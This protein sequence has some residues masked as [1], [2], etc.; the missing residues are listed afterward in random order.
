MFFV[1]RLRNVQPPIYNALRLK[2]RP[3]PETSVENVTPMIDIIL[4]NDQHATIFVANDSANNLANVSVHD[5][6]TDESTDTPTNDVAN[7]N[8]QMISPS[9]M[10]V[11]ANNSA[12]ALDHGETTPES[13]DI[14]PNDVVN[15][16][17][18]IVS[19]SVMNVSANNSAN[20]PIY[21]ESTNEPIDTPPNDV[22]N[23]IDHI[24]SPSVVNFSTVTGEFRDFG[25]PNDDEHH[26]NLN[27]DENLMVIQNAQ[28]TTESDPL[29][30]ASN[31]IKTET[32][33]IHT[34]NADQID[35]LLNQSQDSFD[36]D[37]YDDDLVFFVPK[38]G[39]PQPPIE[40]IS[41]IKRE[42]DE[43]SGDI[44]YNESV[45]NLL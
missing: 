21:D 42:G 13:I 37:V 10:N 2:E 19:P 16:N 41:M 23:Q 15:Q 5:E 38:T 24:I 20:F 25:C 6:T 8:G 39:F 14:S 45:S 7:H 33:T 11:L 44:S 26:Y 12:N 32:T 35:Q 17:G 43:M 9:V 3:I 31:V 29:S 36:E 4:G 1:N 30:I 22:A 34:R 27:T 40:V 18:Q 28:I